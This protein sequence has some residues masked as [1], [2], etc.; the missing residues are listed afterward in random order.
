MTGDGTLLLRLSGKTFT[1][2]TRDVAH[3]DSDT[4][5]DK[6]VIERVAVTPSDPLNT[7][8]IGSALAPRQVDVTFNCLPVLFLSPVLATAT[9]SYC[10]CAVTPFDGHN[11]TAAELML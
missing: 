7:R 3:G 4:G 6:A 10:R 2:T 11:N 5:R 8:L 1:K 9:R